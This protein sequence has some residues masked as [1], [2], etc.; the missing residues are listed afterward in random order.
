ME[1]SLGLTGRQ[2]PMREYC[3]YSC[4]K[5]GTRRCHHLGSIAEDGRAGSWSTC[6]KIV[7]GG[8]AGGEEG[9]RK[10]GGMLA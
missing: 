2:E 9:G 5:S 10:E 1:Q 8:G 4:L 7:K 3:V 6:A